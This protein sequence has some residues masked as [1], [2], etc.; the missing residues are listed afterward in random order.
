MTYLTKNFPIGWALRQAFKEGYNFTSL[1]A[2]LGAGFVVSLIA[3]PISMA[4]AI[5]IGLPPQ[6]GIY[7]AIVAG[8]AAAIFGGS[9]YQ[10]SGP[11]AAFVVI[12][13]PIVAEF[14]LRGLIWCQILAGLMLIFFAIIRLGKLIHYVPYAVNVGFTAGIAVSLATISLKDFL[15]LKGAQSS[16]HFIDKVTHLSTHFNETNLPEAIIGVLTIFFIL[17]AKRITKR[18]PAPMIGV[19]GGSLLGWLL[20]QCGYTIST[21]GSEF[22]FLSLDGNLSYGIPPYS[23]KLQ[24]PTFELGYL[25]SIPSLT[26]LKSFL[27]PA[28]IIAALASL[29]SLLSASIADSLTGTRH[30]PN[31]ELGGIGIANILSG[32]ASGIPAT[33][34]LAR[35][36]TNIQSGAKS[37]LAA[38]FHS[39]FILLYVLILAPFICLVP[40]S[41]LAA[42]LI[43]TAYNMSHLSEFMVIFKTAPV[44]DRLILFSAFVLTVFINMVVGV[45]VGIALAG[46]VFFMRKFNRTPFSLRD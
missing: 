13:I 30:H 9:S 37:P 1:K 22:S 2:D 38:V 5:A 43:L 36:A 39:M 26:E 35:T 29:E 11:T 45:A 25:L 28:L 7:T 34:A 14:G 15:G 4:L 33:A 12:L 20:S 41:V 18:F 32:L 23:P 19:L 31:A 21:I 42:L 8:I 16:P 24:L 40:M 27:G 17:Q 46:L 10:I 44:S 3:L 6:Q